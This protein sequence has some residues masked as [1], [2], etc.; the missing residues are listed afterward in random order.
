MPELPEIETIRLQLGKVLPGKKIVRM[1]VRGAKTVQGDSK[2]VEGKK[3]TGVRRRAKVL[4]VDLEGGMAV[5]FHFKMTGQLI[6]DQDND[7]KTWE[8][9]VV[10]GHPTED[11]ENPMPSKHTRVIFKLDHGTLYFNDQRMFGWVKIGRREEIEQEKFLQSLGPEP[12]DITAD[13]FVKRI[14]K[15]KKPIKLVLMDQEVIAGVGNIYAND[16]LWEARVDP[17]RPAYTLT[18]KQYSELHKGLKKVLNEGI[19][20][21]GAS[22]SDYV[23]AHGLGGKY[24]EH[25]RTYGREGQEC[26]RGD[27]GIVHKFVLGGR[28]TYYCPA[29]QH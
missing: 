2:L 5:A 11:Y 8:D 7:G 28:G 13:D 25:F 15:S 4:I 10:G 17:K 6:L 3:I 14:A 12:F 24:Q 18:A 23:N 22:Y 29:C 1:E 20:Y 21:G 16:A 19:K 27:G 9:R 26:L